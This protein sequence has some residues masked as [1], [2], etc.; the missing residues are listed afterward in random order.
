MSSFEKLLAERPAD[1]RKLIQ[2][3]TK[4]ADRQDILVDRLINKMSYRKIAEKFGFRLTEG[5]VRGL[6]VKYFSHI[7]SNCDSFRAAIEREEFLAQLPP[8]AVQ[9]IHILEEEVEEKKKRIAYLEGVLRTIQLSSSFVFDQKQKTY[10]ELTIDTLDLTVRTSNILMVEDIYTLD[11]LL[12][13]SEAELLRLPG[14][15][16]KK[17]SELKE[18]LREKGFTLLSDH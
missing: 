6:C 14:F 1:A 9:E 18:A 7:E 10:P 5:K 11:Q 16:R 15:G 2:S 12:L 4:F 3:V 17:L 13:K 8:E